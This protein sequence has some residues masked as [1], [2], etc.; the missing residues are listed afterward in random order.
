[1]PSSYEDI[2]AHVAQ[3][4]VALLEVC[5]QNRGLL[6]MLLEG[7]GG[8]PHAY[9]LVEFRERTR[10]RSQEWIRRAIDAGLYRGDVDPEVVSGLVS[11]A[12]E[13]L[14]QDLL[15]RDRKPD[16]DA[17]C[18]QVVDL[19][20]RG[21]LARPVAA[22]HEAS[23]ASSPRRRAAGRPRSKAARIVDPKVR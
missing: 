14:V 23:P 12:Y 8:T 19:F 16:L 15:R 21:L 22:E 7:G 2:V 9:L 20:M 10:T 6:R 3:R 1:M 13:R 5:W 4:D 17:W 11:G 18:R